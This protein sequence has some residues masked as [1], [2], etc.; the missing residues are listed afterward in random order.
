MPRDIRAA[1]DSLSSSRATNRLDITGDGARVA[2]RPGRGTPI[3]ASK[4][5][6]GYLAM[7]LGVVATLALGVG[8]MALM[9]HGNLSDRD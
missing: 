9:Y 1:T 8:L 2:S 5:G 7:T 4:S 3:M 6:A